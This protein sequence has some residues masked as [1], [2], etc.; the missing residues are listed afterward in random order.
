MPPDDPIGMALHAARASHD[1]HFD[2]DVYLDT[3]VFAHVPSRDD[4]L[5]GQL[6]LTLRQSMEAVKRLRAA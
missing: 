4:L 1:H 6:L 3:T 2:L 5:P